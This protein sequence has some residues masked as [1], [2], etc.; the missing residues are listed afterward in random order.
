MG[1][2]GRWYRLI[3]YCLLLIGVGR[4]FRLLWRW[5][6][7]RL[8][9]VI[10]RYCIVRCCI[11]VFDCC[12]D[13]VLC[14][15]VFDCCVLFCVFYIIMRTMCFFGDVV[16]YRAPGIARAGSASTCNIVRTILLHVLVL[17]LIRPQEQAWISRARCPSVDDTHDVRCA[18]GYAACCSVD[19]P[20]Y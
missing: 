7:E 15:I 16:Q 5:Q 9:D 2:T 10:D 8:V 20:W 6:W 1:K 11:N 14:W 4:G 3:L 13:I 17:F 19:P 18:C 12:F